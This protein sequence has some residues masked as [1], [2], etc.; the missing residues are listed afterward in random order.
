MIIKN[1]IRYIW[2]CYDPFIDYSDFLI[3][4]RKSLMYLLF[5]INLIKYEESIN[6]IYPN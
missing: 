6:Q 3:L 5:Y 2:Y 1:Q 4:D